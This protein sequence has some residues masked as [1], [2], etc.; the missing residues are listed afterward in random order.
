[1]TASGRELGP[2]AITVNLANPGPPTP[3]STRPTARMATSSGA[4]PRSAGSRHPPRSPAEI[5][6]AVAFLADPDATSITGTSVTMD[7]GF[8]N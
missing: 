2:R 5:A 8:T 6:G 7:G 1:M 3:N 4:I